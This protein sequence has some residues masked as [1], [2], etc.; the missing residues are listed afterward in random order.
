VA[1]IDAFRGYGNALAENL[2]RATLVLDCFHAVALANRAVDKV[3][4]RVQQNTL[5]HRGRRDDPLYKIRRI[6]LVGAERLNQRG[7]ERL[8]AGL[9]TGDATGQLASAWVAKELFRKVYAAKDPQAARRALTRFYLH[10]ADRADIPELVT[11]AGTVSAWESQILAYHS[12]GGAS[13]SP[14]EAV[15]LLIEKTRRI[16]HG[17]RSFI[18]YRLRLLL[19]CGVTWDTPPVA[20]IRGRQ[21]CSAA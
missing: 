13:N 7:W 19:A 14:T 16:A 6:T 4:R 11:L 9:D 20:R 2:P 8:L 18:N 17:F 10:C 3:R 12:T 21:P 5:G 1:A 15:N